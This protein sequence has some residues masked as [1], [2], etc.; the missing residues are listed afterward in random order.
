MNTD[1]KER[2]DSRNEQGK[3]ESR[4]SAPTSSTADNASV[5]QQP[6]IEQATR[7]GKADKM[8]DKSGEDRT[9]SS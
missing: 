2:F 5:Y 3:S 1:N 8:D 9:H 7:E 4:P 6:P